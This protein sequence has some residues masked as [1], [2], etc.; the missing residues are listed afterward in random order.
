[1]K[2]SQLAS[3]LRRIASK[4][5][6]SKQPSRKLVAKDLKKVLN[7]IAAKT[8]FDEG[9]KISFKVLEGS[10]LE[11]DHGL[12]GTPF[13]EAIR[14]LPTVTSVKLEQRATSQGGADGELI[15][16]IHPESID[17]NET[18][19]H[20]DALTNIFTGPFYTWMREVL[21]G[22]HGAELQYAAESLDN[23]EVPGYGTVVI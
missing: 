17:L 1:M 19:G 7:Q 16:D 15:V 22:K 12:L 10:A 23:G 3:Q 4:I 14:S 6:A 20:F 2:P 18:M 11:F 9:Y 5:D 13:V 8:P 21:D